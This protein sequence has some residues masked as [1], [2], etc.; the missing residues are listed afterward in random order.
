VLICTQSCAAAV[1]GAQ[2]AIPIAM[3]GKSLKMAFM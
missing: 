3:R 1:R 2:S